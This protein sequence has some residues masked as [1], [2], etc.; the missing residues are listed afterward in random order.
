MLGP[1][2]DGRSPPTGPRGV[3]SSNSTHSKEGNQSGPG[4]ELGGT[5]EPL[6]DSAA[7]VSL[8]PG[9]GSYQPVCANAVLL[10]KGQLL[11]AWG[12]GLCYEEAEV[13]YMSHTHLWDYL[14]PKRNPGC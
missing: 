5:S 13:S 9:C 7:Q 2:M 4:P 12:P 3:G 10:G 11:F 14:S 6:E 1:S 8:S